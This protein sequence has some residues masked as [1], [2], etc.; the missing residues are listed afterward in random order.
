[1]SSKEVIVHISLGEEDIRAGK[2]WF[3]HRKGRESASFE[4]DGSWLG[5]PEKFALEPALALTA[6]AFHTRADANVFGAMGDSAPDRW[7]RLLMRR[8]ENARADGENET[9]RTLLEVDYLLG[10]SD[11]ARQGALRFSVEP[12]DTVFLARESQTAAPP[13]VNLSGLLSASERFIENEE[14]AE[15]MKLL[16]APGSSL[17]GTRPKASVRDRDG[18]LAVAKFPRKNDESDA[19]AW[20]AVALALARNAGINVPPWRL[21][22]VLGKPVLITRRF[23]RTGQ[24]R[25][26]FLS[27]M[28][29]LGARD[30]E[31]RSYLEMAYALAQNGGAPEKDME[32]LWRRVVFNVLISNTDDHLRNHGFLYERRRGWRLSPAYD[33]NPTPTEIGPRVLSTAIDFDDP[34]ASLDTAMSVSEDFRLSPEK[35]K[36]TA[37]NIAGATTR[38]R[39]V[40]SDL[41]LSKRETDRMASAFEHDDLRKA[42]SPITQVQ[43]LSGS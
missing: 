17:G 1:M 20:E 41:G 26:P 8:R 6:G 36:K 34:S 32:Q 22:T 10:V 4:Y 39:K 3:H 9:S 28:S 13:L 24:F 33:M 27:A 35:A 19:V 38:W 16:L 14:T 15:D 42:L 29:M 31:Q 37:R 23:D 43:A 7:G 2:L 12:N 11:E 5:H 18:S 21:E 25:I 40:A 30:N